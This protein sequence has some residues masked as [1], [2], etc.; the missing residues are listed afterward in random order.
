LWN[1]YS[2]KY[3]FDES[4]FC[5]GAPHISTLKFG[6]QIDLLA[7]LNVKGLDCPISR[8][9]EQVSELFIG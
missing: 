2:K 1:W 3:R 4:R 6:I 5:W 9:Y 7:N 8:R